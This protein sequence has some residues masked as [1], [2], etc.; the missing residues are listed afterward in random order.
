MTGRISDVMIETSEMTIA[1]LN[2]GNLNGRKREMTDEGIDVIVPIVMIASSGVERRIGK[3]ILLMTSVVIR[4]AKSTARTTEMMDEMNDVRSVARK[5]EMR[6]QMIVMKVVA[7][8]VKL[9]FPQL[10][11]TLSNIR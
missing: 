11:W 3:E 2:A 6:D 9:L 5:D 4:N 8:R 7:R 10:L 1:H